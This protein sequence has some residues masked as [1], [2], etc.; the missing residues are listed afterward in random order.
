MGDP[1]A[2]ATS[3]KVF[4]YCSSGRPL[5][6]ATNNVV[7]NAM[8]SLNVRFSHLPTAMSLHFFHRLI[9]FYISIIE[10]MVELDLV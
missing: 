9:R 3:G 2:D 4:D 6:T 8:L 7:C 10:C 5:A 1:G